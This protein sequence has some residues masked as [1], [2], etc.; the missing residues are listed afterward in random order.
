M[1]HQKKDKATLLEEL[2]KPY[3]ACMKCPLSTLGRINVVF[4]EGSPDAQLMFIGEG[5]GRNEDAQGRPF[6]GRAGKLLTQIIEAMNLKREEVYITNV[7][8]CRPPSNRAPLPIESATCTQLLLFKQIAIIQ[9]RI[10]CTLGAS[11]TQVFLGPDAPISKVRGN[12]F[13]YNGTLLMP[14]YHPAYLLRNPS[15]KRAVWEDMK[16]IM[17]Q[18]ETGEKTP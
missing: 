11:A 7:V 16:K 12:F 17:N 1:H 3:V 6:V 9:P 18:L 8:K 15:Q 2:Y 4:G 10:L 13:T 5:P 14:T